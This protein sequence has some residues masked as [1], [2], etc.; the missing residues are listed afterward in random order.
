MR[1]TL[2]KRN[3]TPR[4]MRTLFRTVRTSTPESYLYL[5]F[6]YRGQRWVE[7]VPAARFVHAARAEQDAVAARH[8]PLG[9]IRGVAAHDADRQ[10]FRDVFRDCEELRHRLERTAEVILVE[11]GH[12]DP[13]TAV[14][15]CVAHRR[16]VQIE[17]LPFVDPHHFGVIVD[18]LQQ[19]L[20]TP[21]VARRD[22]HVAVRDDVGVA[23]AVVDERLEDLDL[24]PGDLRAPQPSNQLLALAAEHAA[25][26]DFD[27]PMLR[28]FS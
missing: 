8:E 26:D 28:F 2:A 13:L 10:R 27:P 23:V 4:T 25:G 11:P 15:Q 22:A 14:R 24:L 3:P 20:R 12:D 5:D 7:A 17:E 16:Q 1:R 19:L 18:E 6:F 21:D 9:V